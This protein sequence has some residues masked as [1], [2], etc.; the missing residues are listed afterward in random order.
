[1]VG[2]GADAGGIFNVIERKGVVEGGCPR[3]GAD[4]Q[5]WFADY[6]KT[7]IEVLCQNCGRFLIPREDYDR[8]ETERI[9][10]DNYA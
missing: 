5:W 10:T 6:A 1:L 4:A 2:R 3:C 8:V 7:R 9:E